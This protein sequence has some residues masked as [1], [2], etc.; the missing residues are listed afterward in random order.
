MPKT[1]TSPSAF[2]WRYLLLPLC[3]SIFAGMYPPANR[4][5]YALGGNVM[6]TMIFTA[7]GRG[8]LLLLFCLVTKKPL[9]RTRADLKQAII[10][11]FYQAI[12]VLCVV[13]SLE[14]LPG[15]IVIIV[16]FSHSLMLLFF[17]AWRGEI[18]L[19]AITIASTIM[20]LFGLSLAVDFWHQHLHSQWLGLG[21][22]FI[23]ALATV[24]RLYVYGH[25]MK[26]RNPAIV[27]AEAY[28]FAILFCLAAL[29]FKFPVPP[30][31]AA[32]WGWMGLSALTGGIAAILMFYGIAR[33]GAFKWSLFAKLEPIFTSLFSFLFLRE[34]LSVQ[35]YLGIA[36]VIGSLITYQ[37]ETVRQ[38]K[39]LTI[40]KADQAS[41]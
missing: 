19:D 40:L 3:A 31:S 22:A 12:T 38:Q 13:A 30:V 27:G 16:I 23:A 2:S 11:G 34:I 20:A 41:P 17:L 18:K 36:L 6:F 32:G 39:R 25:Q 14:Y 28:V 29:L 8:L 35:E 1:Q 21:L 4:A 33:L 7:L 26:L 37:I 24:S 15:P 10:G 9:F 5:V